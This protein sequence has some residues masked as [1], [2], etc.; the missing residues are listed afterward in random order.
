[1]P[2]AE[3]S[4]Y[5]HLEAAL[6]GFRRARGIIKSNGD[7]TRPLQY[8]GDKFA[9]YR[10]VNRYRMAVRFRGIVLDGFEQP[11]TDGYAALTRAF[12]A[13][14]VFE[15]YAALCN[16][17]CPYKPLLAHV[18]KIQ[19]SQLA[20]T[21]ER[22][23]RDGKFHEFLVEQSV[24]T[25]SRHGSPADGAQPDGLEKFH[26]GDRRAV[27]FHAAAIR[28]I[29]VHGHLTAHPNG[30]SSEDTQTICHAV[31][32]FLFQMIREDFSRRLKL[33]EAQGHSACG[34]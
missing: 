13:W 5:Q 2:A 9:F 18:P 3:H 4:D 22:A 32:D 11:T 12:L 34:K 6:P 21:I 14:S 23:D 10:F 31:S 20:D 1:M 25:K 16:V 33:A 24:F 26:D 27:L 8:V 17:R 19:L 28:H 30:C 7:S 29:Y 15:R